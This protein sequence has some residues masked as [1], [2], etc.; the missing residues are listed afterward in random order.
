MTESPDPAM[1]DGLAVAAARA[2]LASRARKAGSGEATEPPA[3]GT[4]G[5]IGN[6]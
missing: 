2:T 1:G 3:P 4:T 6:A 5:Q